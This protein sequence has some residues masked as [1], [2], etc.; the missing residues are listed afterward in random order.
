MNDSPSTYSTARTRRLFG[1]LALAAGLLT[2]IVI[3]ASAFI[4]HT[5][6]GL[7]CAPWPA[8]YARIDAHAEA[9]APPI[10]VFIARLVHRLAASGALA[11]IIGMWLTARARRPA[12]KREHMLGLAALVV[13]AGLAVLG[14]VTPGAELPAVPLGNLLGG[15][16]MVAVLAALT[17]AA[18]SPDN[19]TPQSPAT[20]PLRSIAL[21]LL[22]FAFVQAGLGA[23]IGTQF[24][25]TACAELAHCPA[26]ASNEFALGAALDPFRRLAIVDGHAVAPAGAAGIHVMHR[27]LGVGLA[28]TALVLAYALRSTDRRAARFLMTLALATPLLGAT[29][30]VAM[31]S[32]AV[33]VLHNATAAA[34]IAT[35]A[36]VA[37]RR[38]VA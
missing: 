36:Y 2:L 17:A 16:L 18:A 20:T 10:G 31:P 26:F 27:L 14:M 1:R 38:T 32:L 33:T 5:Q 29:A 22:A 21:A 6:A 12:L 28:T 13:A 4:R 24:A 8:C 9:A 15:Y 34:L 3:A 35:L 19:A 37:A 25:L 23:L 11:L 30:V 7:A